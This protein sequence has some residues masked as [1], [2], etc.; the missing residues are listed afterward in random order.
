MSGR[1]KAIRKKRSDNEFEVEVSFI[2]PTFFEDEAI[3]GGK[4]TVREASRIL[5]E[6]VVVKVVYT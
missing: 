6:G 5:G 1:I 4:F 3:V 2:E